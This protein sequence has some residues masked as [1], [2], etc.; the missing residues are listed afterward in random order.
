MYE[1][2]GLGAGITE[3]VR[4]FW[5]GAGATSVPVFKIQLGIGAAVVLMRQVSCGVGVTSALVF[6]KNLP[7]PSPCF[8]WKLNAKL[9]KMYEIFPFFQMIVVITA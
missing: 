9:Q 8:H 7:A 1:N 3:V 2:Q 5:P 6:A 4:A